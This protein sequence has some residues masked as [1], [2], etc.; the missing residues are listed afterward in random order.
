M[1][2]ARKLTTALPA[3]VG[4]CDRRPLIVVGITHAQTC[5]VL[6]GRLRALK[7]AGF[8][9]VLISSPGE[10]LDR[11]ATAEG[12]DALPISIRR[13][14]APLSDVISLIRLCRVLHRLQPD[15]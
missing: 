9:V 3:S 2:K 1:M 4:D 12:V 15:V 13:G 14:M 10:L 8:R 6:T 5:L 11:L 7:A